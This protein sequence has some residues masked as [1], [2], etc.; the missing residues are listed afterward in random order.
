MEVKEYFNT[1]KEEIE[2]KKHNIV[3]PICLGN[4]F[5]ANKGI[6]NEN[7]KKYLD[8]SLKHTKDKVLFTIIDKI[9]DTNYFVR[10]KGSNE[11]QSL[12]RVLKEDKMKYVS[13]LPQGSF[14]DQSFARLHHYLVYCLRAA[15]KNGLLIIMTVFI[16]TATTGS[17]EIEIVITV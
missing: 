2:S 12:R 14:E 1:T 7:V 13:L 9:Q 3:I 16:F 8:W 11:K 17:F 5:F 15:L 10:N 6:L 4:K